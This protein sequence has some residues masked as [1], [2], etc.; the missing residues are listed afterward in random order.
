MRECNILILP[1]F[2]DQ[3]NMTCSFLSYIY[4]SML[5]HFGCT[6]V[7]LV[8]LSS[9]KRNDIIIRWALYI[10]VNKAQAYMNWC[11]DNSWPV[12]RTHGLATTTT[13]KP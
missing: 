8:L 11:L 9:M 6:S 5:I 10:D 2:K 4:D 13:A 12:E 3:M 1:I 7:Q